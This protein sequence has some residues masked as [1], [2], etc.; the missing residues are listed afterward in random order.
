[1]P[2]HVAFCANTVALG[3]AVTAR[4]KSGGGGVTDNANVCVFAAGAPV[5]FAASVTVVGPPTG[6]FA[7]ALTVIV[8]V[9]GFDDVGIA[10][11]DGENWQVVPDGNPVGQLKFTISENEPAAET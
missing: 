10:A 6:E 3:V 9:T 4:A 7:A 8:T 5:T 11:L 2:F 1:M